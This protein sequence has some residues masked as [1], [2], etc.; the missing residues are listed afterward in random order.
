M[1]GKE[2]LT[3]DRKGR[4]MMEVSRRAELGGK[5]GIFVILVVLAFILPA[6]V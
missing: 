6:G 3:P 4:M 1:G 5:S 2:I